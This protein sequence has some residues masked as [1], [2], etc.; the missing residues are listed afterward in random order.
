MDRANAGQQT[1]KVFREMFID[2]IN[3]VRSSLIPSYIH[4]E[5]RPKP[6]GKFQSFLGFSEGRR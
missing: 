2:F 3:G 6:A 4:R 5:I 1:V